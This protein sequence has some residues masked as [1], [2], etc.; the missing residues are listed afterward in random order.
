MMSKAVPVCLAFVVLAALVA[1]NTTYF[2]PTLKEHL[3]ESQHDP[4]SANL[5]KAPD[6]YWSMSEQDLHRFFE[7]AGDEGRAI[8]KTFLL[9]DMLFTPSLSFL[10]YSLLVLLTPSST[11][12]G[13]PLLLC[14]DLVENIITLVAL[15][16]H[17]A[18]AAPNVLYL[19]RNMASTTKYASLYV[20]LG[21]IVVLAVVAPVLKRR[22]QQ[23]GQ[24]L[25]K[26]D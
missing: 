1:L 10:L 12:R 6:G 15:A 16:A 21:V 5:I 17:P 4:S 2:M 22:K 18:H 26:Q 14:A 24:P 19:L 11:L 23:Q 20:T 13:L 8:Y 25:P 7:D 9:C 3:P